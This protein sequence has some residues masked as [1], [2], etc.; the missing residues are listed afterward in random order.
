MDDPAT[1]LPALSWKPED[2]GS[3][4][5]AVREYVEREALRQVAWY[6]AKKKWKMRMSSALRVSAIAFFTL[7]G[8][9]PLIKA[10]FPTSALTAAATSRFDFGQLGYLLIGIGAA[11][12]ALDR[13][14]GYSSGW[15]RYIT[16]ALAIERSLDD[17]RLEWTRSIAALRGAEPGV[18]QVDQ[19]VQLCKNLAM[20]VRA[21][22]EQ[23]TKAW[24]LEFQSNLA[25][26]EKALK[27][28][29][30]E[31]KTP[32]AAAAGKV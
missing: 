24:V 27:A 16:A 23:E 10:T 14:F 11:S 13:F 31:A 5:N 4:L 29:E 17:F 3:S 2:F 15:I 1:N 22:V 7:G 25:D 30:E 19:L 21:Q 32:K 6:Y 12:I 26:L 8:L 18:E 28:R 9:I 20:G